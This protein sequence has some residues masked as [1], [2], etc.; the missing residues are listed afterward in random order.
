M[1]LQDSGRTSGVYRRSIQFVGDH[2]AML[3]DGVGLSLVPWRSVVEQRL[4]EHVSAVVR[5][6]SVTWEVGRLSR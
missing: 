3:D 5:G 6:L 4:G 2:F 1:Q